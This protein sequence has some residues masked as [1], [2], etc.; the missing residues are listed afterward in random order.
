MFRLLKFAGWLS[1]ALW[2]QGL[3]GQLS[4]VLSPAEAV[5][6][7]TVIFR[8]RLNSPLATA[9]VFPAAL[10]WT[11][12]FSTSTIRS[13]AVDDGP[14][15]EAADKTAMC[16]GDSSVHRCVAAGRN[17]N[18][19]TP[20]VIVKVTVTLVEKSVQPVLQVCDPHASSSD[21]YSIPITVPET[22]SAAPPARTRPKQEASK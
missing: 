18:I 9:T 10:Q 5:D 1:L 4:L 20:G 8:L 13:I 2:P 22:D 7:G 11:F 3:Y 12:R 6:D 15:L 14:A 17:S 19:V 16:T 21:G